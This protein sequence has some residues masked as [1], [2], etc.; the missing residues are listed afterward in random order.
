M[1][2]S[3]PIIFI[4]LFVFYSHGFGESG[5]EAGL[6]MGIYFQNSENTLRL[7]PGLG[8]SVGTRI[9]NFE[10]F[11]CLFGGALFGNAVIIGAEGYYVFKTGIINP[12]IGLFLNGN[13]GTY[14]FF[15]EHYSGSIRPILPEF[16]VGIAVKPL[17]FTIEHIRLSFL[18][19]SAGTTFE[20]FGR[21]FI[22]ECEL[23]SISLLF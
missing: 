17:V 21:I 4:V 22:A 7:A 16:G 15:T 9:D 1:L 13:F 20:Y 10:L 12:R 2:K 8:I 18:E 19:L 23:F 3:W 11:A 5:I 6:S 14:L